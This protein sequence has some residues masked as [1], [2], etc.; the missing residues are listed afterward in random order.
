MWQAPS[1]APSCFPAHEDTVQ[2]KNPRRQTATAC[3]KAAE[4][5][6][7]AGGF[8]LLVID[9]GDAIRFIPQSSALRLARIAER[10]GAAIIILAQAGY[11]CQ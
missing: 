2:W 7:A 9:F 5:I 11:V 4:W 6:L 8:G 3:L 10:S 1:I